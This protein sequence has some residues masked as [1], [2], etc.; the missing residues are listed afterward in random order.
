MK[1]SRQDNRRLGPAAAAMR[2]RDVYRD[3]RQAEEQVSIQ[4]LFRDA[5]AMQKFHSPNQSG[6]GAR[7]MIHSREELALYRQKRRAELE[8]SVRR[9]FKAIGNWIRY[10]RW[11]AQQRDFDRMRAVMERAVPVHGENANL[12]RDYAELEESNGFAEHARQVWSRGVTALPSSV[13]LW[14][15]YLAME[16]AAGQDQRV[17]D[18]FHR[19]LAG[20]AVPPCAYALAALYEAQQ[21]RQAG[22]RDILRRCVE[23]FNTPASWLLYGATEQQVFGDHERAVRVLETAMHALPDED[24]WGLEECRVP[25]ALAEAHVAAGNAV[26]A[27]N[28][29]HNAL[30]H[31]ADHPVLLEKVL[32]SYSRF[33]RLYGDGAHSEQVA[34]LLT[35]QLYEE[36]LRTNTSD[37]DAYLTLY[38]LYRDQERESRLRASG[39]SN[40]M[41]EPVV[42][43]N[44]APASAALATSTAAGASPSR[45]VLERAL[46]IPARDPYGAQQ[47]A[48]LIMEYARACEADGE[49]DA[50]RRTL[51]QEIKNFPFDVALCPRLWVE[52]A[53]M[54]ERHG[55]TA[56]ARRLLR[57]GS[58]V[59]KD[60]CL[61]EEAIQFE[62]RQRDSVMEAMHAAAHETTPP[63]AREVEEAC[64]PYVAELRADYQNAIQ[65]FPFD[66]QWWLRYAKLEEQQHEILRA[67]ALYGACIRTF[68]DEAERVRSFAQRY[69]LL[70]HVD[71]AWA[72]RI[73][74]HT[75]RARALQ[76]QASRRKGNAAGAETARAEVAALQE[77][78]LH[79]YPTFLQDVWNAYRHEAVAWFSRYFEA[80]EG[81]GSGVLAGAAP[82]T[83]PASLTPATARWSEA[84]EAVAGYMERMSAIKAGQGASTGATAALRAILKSMVEAERHAI[85]RS[86]GW[87]EQTTQFDA[88]QRAREWGE[89][90]LSPLLE[91][92]SKFELTHGGSLEAVAA[93]MEKPVKRRTRL[94]K[95]RS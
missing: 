42:G 68:N 75:R 69:D 87:T 66:V 27:R 19:W 72:H 91:E 39:S 92:W 47:R 81:S 10:A 49:L 23:R 37:F 46:Q 15:K 67:D 88:V 93:A 56:Q 89:L 32:A 55:A 48:V 74:L 24:L 65:A 18:I 30:E 53:A 13:D 6:A 79:L 22:C 41:P 31:V 70:S 25:L 2:R 78:L 62:E 26:Q 61:F 45:Q 73:H 64:A 80:G 82:K 40:K 8:E 77:E 52:A 83:L 95:A 3:G 86:L 44:A 33:E 51:A 35:I 28:V 43:G 4:K 5:V 17:R 50:A 54:E 76:R 94:F 57:A 7:V 84:V 59:T 12:W 16:Q 20:D 29:F 90:L 85:R 9:G 14:V 11:E 38:S 71:A 34:R 36:R 63:S 1:R 60:A 21:R 58:Q